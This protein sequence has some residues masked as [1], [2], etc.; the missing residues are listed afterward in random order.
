[1]YHSCVLLTNSTGIIIYNYKYDVSL[2]A[3][4]NSV[5][6]LHR[7]FRTNSSYVCPIELDLPLSLT[8]TAEANNI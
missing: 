4:A 7:I 2:H 1:M 3:L 8:V 5:S 6:C